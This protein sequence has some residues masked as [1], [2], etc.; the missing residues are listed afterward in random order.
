MLNRGRERH[1]DRR[2]ASS[3]PLPHVFRSLAVALIVIGGIPPVGVTA[4]EPRLVLRKGDSIA[5]I[6]NTLADRMQHAGWL[7]TRI[8]AA[9]YSGHYIVD[10]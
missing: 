2:R 10:L 8:H 3:C 6:G 5:V 9:Y 7:E 4:A 1:H